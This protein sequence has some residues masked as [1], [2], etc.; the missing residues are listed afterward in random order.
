MCRAIYLFLIGLFFIYSDWLLDQYR[1]T[2]AAEAGDWM[3]VAVGWEIAG[4][5]W[6]LLTLSAVLASTVT[7][8]AMG[9]GKRQCATDCSSDSSQQ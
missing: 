7:Y 9:G 3:P 4:E 8:F 6:P 2:I 1:L 5:L